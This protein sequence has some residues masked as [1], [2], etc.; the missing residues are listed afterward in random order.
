MKKIALLS[1]HN[2]ANYGAALQAFA[3]Q[4]ALTR[5]GY[6]CEYI[7]YRNTYRSNAYNMSYHVWCSLKARKLKSA[8]L[9]FLGTPFMCLRK[10][11]FNKFYRR[12]LH[13]TASIYHSSAEAKVL[14][15]KYDKFIVGS[16]QVWNYENNGRDFAF[17]L[18]FVTDDE[19]K[20][21]YSSSF[22]LS[23]VPK[24]L[25]KEYKYNLFV[26]CINYAELVVSAS[27]HCIALSIILN[28]PF[29]AIL[30]GDTGKD[31]R[32][33]SILQLL[34]LQNRI[35]SPSMTLE[36]INLPINYESVNEEIFRLRKDSFQFLINSIEK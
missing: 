22:G 4:E 3:L 25:R 31:E 20:I 13:C 36:E 9:Y 30:T 24:D 1:F 2:A 28:K 18:D 34:G 14:N 8:F 29:I 5:K 27:F 35:Y 15:D 12:Y 32:V 17:L 11:R 7:D 16:D 33:L 23:S 26:S 10:Y 19:K 21:S 6:V